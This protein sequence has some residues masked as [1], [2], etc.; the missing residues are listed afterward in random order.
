MIC[1]S[2][3]EKLVTMVT[4]TQFNVDL[5]PN[6]LVKE[7]KTRG[8]MCR[9]ETFYVQPVEGSRSILARIVVL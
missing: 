4:G 9:V 8:V 2:H 1:S 3:Y 7:N 6:H 5:F